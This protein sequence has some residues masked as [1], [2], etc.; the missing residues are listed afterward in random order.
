MRA[1]RAEANDLLMLLQGV[2]EQKVSS[3]LHPILHS[4]LKVIDMVCYTLKYLWDL[5][6]GAEKKLSTQEIV[7]RSAKRVGLFVPEEMT[8]TDQA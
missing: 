1:Y 4:L 5:D 2:E 3:V 7:N 6:A 8:F